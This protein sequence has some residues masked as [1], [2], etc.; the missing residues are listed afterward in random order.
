MADY[1]KPINLVLY[2]NKEN[3]TNKTSNFFIGDWCISPFFNNFEILKDYSFFEYHWNDRNKLNL[4]HQYLER[5]YER[6]LVELSNEL[7]KIHAKERNID[8]WRIII[9]PWLLQYVAVIYDRW[10]VSDCIKKEN[11]NFKASIIVN[12]RR[13]PPVECNEFTQTSCQQEWNYDLYSSILLYRKFDNVE[14]HFAEQGYLDQQKINYKQIV[15]TNFAH[16]IKKRLIRIYDDIA[17]YINKFLLRSD[18]FITLYHTYFPKFFHFR[19]ALKLKVLPRAHNSFNKNLQSKNKLF[20]YHLMSQFDCENDFEKFLCSRISKD[21]PKSYLEDFDE[22]HSIQSNI[23]Q[24]KIIFT[25]NAHLNNDL[26]KIWMA[27]CKMNGSKIIVSAHGGGLYP[28]FSVFNHQEK[29]SYK[30]IVWGKEWMENHHRL[31]P[32]KLFFKNWKYKKNSFITLVTYNSPIFATRLSSQ[33]LTTSQVKQLLYQW[34]DFSNYLDKNA[35]DQLRIKTP[36]VF[37]ERRDVLDQK[38]LTNYFGYK[39]LLSDA[40]FTS[41]IKKSKIII[42]TYPQTTLS[43][44]IFSGIP[45]ILL[46]KEDFFE[47]IDLHKKVIDILKEAEIYHTCSKTAAKHINKIYNNPLLWWNSDICREAI[48]EFKKICLT[49]NKK[50]IEAWSDFFINLKN[51]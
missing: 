41:A 5:L 34:K 35:R 28:K 27:E 45:T 20:D 51:E 10:S 21:I 16:S 43:E 26:F 14:L 4:D 25:S 23:K 7:S 12:N 31:P 6:T 15:Q 44:S 47:I 18:D 3:A 19:L 30:R 11:R 38:K 1:I 17:K 37:L 49:E 42:C 40:K 8:Y 24:T 46:M 29:I 36:A 50:P 2:G 32:N 33:A 48:H 13:N 22:L 9:G 39:N